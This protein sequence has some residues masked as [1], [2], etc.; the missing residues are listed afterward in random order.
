MF[1]RQIAVGPMQNFCYLIGC[2]QTKEAAAID[3]GFEAEKIY[4]EATANDYHITK[5][6]LTHVHYDHSGAVEE[7]AA[8]TS[9]SIFMNPES[10]KK[11]GQSPIHG[12]W[13]I[14]HNTNPL[15]ANNIIKVGS[16][17]GKVMASPGHQNDHLMFV[18]DPYLFSGDTL[19]IEGTGR[20]DLPD[21]DP[22][23]MQETLAIMGTL[24]DHLIV[25][26]GHDY[27]SVPMRTLGEEKRANRFLNAFV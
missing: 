26:A 4:E 22:E 6:L 19:F 17:K 27:G 10:N 2:E 9:G 7:L 16:L 18:F 24:P 21:S 5:I 13:I 3:C 25:C 8:L 23:K 20:T 14:P 1:F 11:Q 15:Q 12:H